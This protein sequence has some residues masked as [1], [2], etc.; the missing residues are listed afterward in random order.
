MPPMRAL[1]ALLA[2]LLG[3][4]ALPAHAWQARALQDIAVYPERA[5]QAQVVSLNESKV[6]AQLAARV[7][8]LPVEPGQAIAKGALLARLDCTDYDLAVERAQAGLQASEARAR[9]AALQHQRGVKLAGENFLS[10]DALDTRLA[11][12]DG[13]RAEVALATVALK[14]ARADQAKCIVRAPF[15][16]IVLERLTQQGETAAPG[17]PLVRLLDTSRIEVQAQVQ[18]ADAAGLKTARDIRFVAPEGRFELRLARLSPAVSRATRLSEARLRFPGRRAAT[19]TSGRVTWASPEPHLP[20]NVV[21]RRAGRLGVFVVESGQPR[22]HPLP[23]AQEGRPAK[24][25]GLSPTSQVVVAGQ[26]TL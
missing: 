17:T 22:F 8:G 6:A 13:A 12:L 9:L 21:V 14:T 20:A 2:A 7:V 5:A 4:L 26:G 15:P 23:E 1:L 10:K 24:A 25:T 3:L 19:G 18:E 11:E 16:A